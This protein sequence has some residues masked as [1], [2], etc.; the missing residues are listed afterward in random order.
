MVFLI[1][2]NKKIANSAA[3]IRLTVNKTLSSITVVKKVDM[4]E[5]EAVAVLGLAVEVLRVPCLPCKIA[6]CV[7]DVV[8]L[9][10]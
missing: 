9:L 8:F 5:I 3:S 1:P 2:I 7:G 4:M 6:F 10:L